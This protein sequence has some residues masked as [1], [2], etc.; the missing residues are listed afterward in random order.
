MKKALPILLKLAVTT[1]LLGVIFREH[2]FTESILPHLRVLGANWMWTLAGL[3]SVGLSIWLSAL[4]WEVLLR[5][6]FSLD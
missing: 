2:R 1:V 4:R 3:A 6:S 5:G